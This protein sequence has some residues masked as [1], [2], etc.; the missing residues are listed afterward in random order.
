MSNKPQYYTIREAA[1][2]AGVTSQTI[3]NRIDKAEKETGRTFTTTGEDK[4]KRV[5]ADFLREFY[6]I[7]GDEAEEAR[8]LDIVARLED[9][10]QRERE[11]SREE[12][13]RLTAEID[14]LHTEIT[15]LIQMNMNNQ[16]LLL[17]E[18]KPAPAADESEGANDPTAPEANDQTADAAP[19][20]KKGL[21]DRIFGRDND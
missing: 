17:M 18:K 10:L 9:E 6:G 2:I 16:T 4:V 13:E 14:R 19:V 7:T 3:Y 8:K 21:F 11:R 12:R 15:Q 20:K 1:T 5:S